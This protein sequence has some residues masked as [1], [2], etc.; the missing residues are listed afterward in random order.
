MKIQTQEAFLPFRKVAVELLPGGNKYMTLTG[1]SVGL[2]NAG[3]GAGMGGVGGTMAGG[4]YNMVNGDVEGE[5]QE[6]K[7]VR[8]NRNRLRGAL[9]G[10]ILGGSLGG[11]RSTKSILDTPESTFDDMSDK[12]KAIWGGRDIMTGRP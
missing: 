6:A 7:K 2:I 5:T 11:L 9:L 4:L 1:N 3:L 12:F 10:T 8:E